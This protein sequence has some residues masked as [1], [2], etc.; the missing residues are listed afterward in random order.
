MCIR[1][2]F[3]W[4]VFDI[5]VNTDFRPYR[6]TATALRAAMVFYKHGVT[7]S[8]Y[9]AV[10]TCDLT[11][12]TITLQ[13]SFFFCRHVVLTR[14]LIGVTFD[15]HVAVMTLTLQLVTWRFK[16]SQPQRTI[17]GQRETLIKRYVVERTTKAEIRRQEQSE[18]AE[19]CSEN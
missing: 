12:K 11:A 16:P 10:M 17:S 15:H 8:H 6:A 3:V 13:P 1:D 9:V 5:L 19:S 18:K 2:S 7:F 14:S 4:S